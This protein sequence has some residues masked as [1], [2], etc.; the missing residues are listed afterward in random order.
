[1]SVELLMNVTPSETRVAYIED[2]ILQEIH[3]DR[4]S[5]RGIVGNIYKGKVIRIL[6]GMQTAFVDIGHYITFTVFSFNAG[7]KFDPCCYITTN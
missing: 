7:V 1:M 2:G 3:V 4:E 6:P 5:R